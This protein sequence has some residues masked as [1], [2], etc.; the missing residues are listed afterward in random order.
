MDAVGRV[1]NDNRT[2]L[3][4]VLVAGSLLWY[5]RQVFIAE[6]EQ[7]HSLHRW[8]KEQGLD[9]YI[10]NLNKAGVKNKENFSKLDISKFLHKYFPNLHGKKYSNSYHRLEIHILKLQN[11]LKIFYWLE[12]NGLEQYLD[13]LVDLGYSD[14]DDIKE[15]LTQETIEKITRYEFTRNHLSRFEYALKKLRTEETSRPGGFWFRLL[16]YPIYIFLRVFWLIVWILRIVVKAMG[17][18]LFS[19]YLIFKVSSIV[20]KTLNEC[21]RRKTNLLNYAIGNYLYATRTRIRWHWSEPATVGQTMT[22]VI[23]VVL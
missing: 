20:R 14:M 11:H 22:F 3:L 4:L 13:V 10:N 17:F 7:K 12:H 16:H 8:L 9:E 19:L 21:Q 5:Q 15:N 6:Q 2:L 23:E 1:V 18:L